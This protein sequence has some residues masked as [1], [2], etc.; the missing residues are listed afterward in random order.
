MSTPPDDS[1]PMGFTAAITMLRPGPG[2][3]VVIRTPQAMGKQKAERMRR[4]VDDMLAGTGAKALI[5]PEVISVEIQRS[6]VDE[7]PQ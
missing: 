3:V 1:S 5:L 2:D 7:P 4:M 6:G